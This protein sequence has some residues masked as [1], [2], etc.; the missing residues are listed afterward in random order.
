MS[1][2]SEDAFDHDH[3]GIDDQ[4]KVDC[5]DGEQV[6]RLAAQHHDSNGKKQRERDG[7]ADNERAAQVTKEQPLQ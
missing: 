1:K 5:T 6:C 3:G 4:A 2:P 7:G